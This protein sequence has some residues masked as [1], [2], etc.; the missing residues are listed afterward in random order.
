MVSWGDFA[1]EEPALSSALRSLLYQYGQGLAYLATVRADG[2]PRVHPVSPVIADGGL[3]C[4]IIDSPKRRDLRRDGRYALHTYPPEET[5]D[6]G[7]LT[8]LAEPVSDDVRLRR[9]AHAMRADPQV[10]WGL[11]E[12]SVDSAMVVRRPGSGAGSSSTP[13]DREVG[14]TIWRDRGLLRQRAS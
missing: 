1:I 8:G 7:Y 4:F 10:D 2:G 5:D 3:F 14:R 12:L 11:F 6:E 9:L 13:G